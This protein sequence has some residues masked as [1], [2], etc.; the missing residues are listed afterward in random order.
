MK[1]EDCYYLGYVSKCY[2]K[3]GALSAK[4]DVDFPDDY[5]KLESVLVLMQKKDKELVP[6]FIQEC[7]V[8]R[9]GT[10]RMKWDG[11][12]SVETSKPLVGKELYLPLSSLPKLTGLQFYYHEIKGFRVVDVDKGIIGVVDQVLEYPHQAVMAVKH[13][14]GKEVLI[15]IMEDNIKKLNRDHKEI[16]LTTPEGLIDLYLNSTGEEQKDE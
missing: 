7:R 5:N 11:I 1:I 16:T 12:D 9:D 2:G 8:Q 10:L 15:P 14:S 13:P 4:L 3:K 6:F